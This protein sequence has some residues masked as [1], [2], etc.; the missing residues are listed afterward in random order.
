MTCSQCKK[1]LDTTDISSGRCQRCG[2]PLGGVQAGAPSTDPALPQP[3]AAGENRAGWPTTQAGPPGALPDPYNAPLDP[4]ASAGASPQPSFDTGDPFGELPT[5]AGQLPA[6]F[7][8]GVNIPP[9]PFSAP[10]VGASPFPVNAPPPPQPGFAPGGAFAA[11]PFQLPPATPPAPPPPARRRRRGRKG[12]NS[13]LIIGLTLLLLALVGTTILLIQGLR[14][15]GNSAK[16]GATATPR[17]TVSRTSTPVPTKSYRDPDGRF[18]LSYP[19]GWQTEHIQ[20]QAGSLALLSGVQ[21]KQGNAAFTVVAGLGP[22]FA[23]P[24]LAQALDDALLRSMDARNVS[25]PSSV[26]I[27][28]QTWTE[29]RADTDKGRMVMDAIEF[30]GQLYALWYNAPP[31][32]FSSDESGVFVPIRASFK[33][34]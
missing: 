33:F 24:G 11:G 28:G 20:T 27:G 12:K 31:D 6:V 5:E 10:P 9:Q 21:F 8:P 23:P 2:T 29:E 26:R 13:L 34:G 7:A 18:S 3:N 22:P 30:N 32:E 1:H 4:L 16:D 25:K 17:P 19:A 14:P 15:S